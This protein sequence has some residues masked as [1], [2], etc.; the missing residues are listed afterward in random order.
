MFKCLD[1]YFPVVSSPFVKWRFSFFYGDAG[2]D[3]H[4]K[5]QKEI[6]S[7]AALALPVTSSHKILRFSYTRRVNRI[8]TH[9][10]TLAP[11]K[12]LQEAVKNNY[13]YHHR[14]HQSSVSLGI[15][16][17]RPHALGGDLGFLLMQQAAATRKRHMARSS[18]QTCHTQ[19]RVHSHAMVTRGRPAPLV[20]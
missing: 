16:S 12:L 8:N 15:A 10:V 6:I 17:V 11:T 3:T 2:L 20:A 5:K 13:Y 7:L 9:I 14:L 1:I 19:T 18:N 4:W